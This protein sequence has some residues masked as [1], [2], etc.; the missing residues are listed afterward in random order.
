MASFDVPEA[1]TD[2]KPCRAELPIHLQAETMFEGDNRR[3]QHFLTLPR[4]VEPWRERCGHTRCSASK[5]SLLS[6]P[7]PVTAKTG[8][9]IPLPGQ[10]LKSRNRTLGKAGAKKDRHP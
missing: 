10:S 1:V 7:V 4:R 5:V 2:R 9:A 3:L 8:L 6:H